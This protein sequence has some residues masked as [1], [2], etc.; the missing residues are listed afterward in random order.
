MTPRDDRLAAALQDCLARTLAGEPPEQALAQQPDDLRAELRPALVA[1]LTVRHH[2][3]A[4][5]AAFADRLQGQL[6]EAMSQLR[7]PLRVPAPWW[8]AW[9]SPRLALRLTAMLVAVALAGMS[10]TLASANSRP[11]D[12][13]YPVHT[14][15]QRL[16]AAGWTFLPRLQE[17][18]GESAS[19]A[20]PLRPQPKAS[21]T[22]A[23][24][25]VARQGV[26]GSVPAA[27]RAI[28][29]Q[30]DV[31][32][33]AAM[34]RGTLGL[35]QVPLATATATRTPIASATSAAS[36]TPTQRVLPPTALP[37]LV[38]AAATAL[39]TD[40]PPPAT[41]EAPD[42]PPAAPSTPTRPPEA[43][44]GSIAGR[45]TDRDGQP[46]EGARV[47]A[48]PFE[49]RRGQPKPPG[50]SAVTGADGRYRIA[51][52]RP[53]RYRVSADDSPRR[54]PPRWYPGSRDEKD[55]EPVPVRPG[56]ETEGID[57]A[58]ERRP[59]RQGDEPGAQPSPSPTASPGPSATGTVPE[60]TPTP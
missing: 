3:P 59:G 43:G 21:S 57:I 29:P 10:L 6:D 11:G 47:R 25:T 22:Q 24:T 32:P 12:L 19:P 56:A 34:A 42:D 52:L 16:G 2:R 30:R 7:P 23:A 48:E 1:A 36:P 15:V 50:G 46:V 49:D 37:T 38:P 35:P 58:L 4:P 28:T 33:V 45:I 60:P 14:L 40:L 31:T 54:G 20:L 26:E 17:S 41:D 5:S 51:G 8:S 55:A 44:P 53:G 18:S 27:E 39:P 13:L 9:S